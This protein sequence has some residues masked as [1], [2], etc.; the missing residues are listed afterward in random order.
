MVVR[1]GRGQLTVNKL[2]RRPEFVLLEAGPHGLNV[3]TE[4]DWSFKAIVILWSNRVLHGP[5][6]RIRDLI[7]SHYIARSYRGTV[8]LLRAPNHRLDPRQRVSGFECPVVHIFNFLL[9]EAPFR[10]LV[11]ESAPCTCVQVSPFD[12]L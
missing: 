6:K 1:R 5:K 3:R 2:L 9:G 8:Y 7:F 11:S 10:D 12:T 4:F